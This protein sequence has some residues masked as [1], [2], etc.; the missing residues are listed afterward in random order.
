MNQDLALSLRK[1]EVT[2]FSEYLSLKAKIE[3]KKALMYEMISCDIE[4]WQL[5]NRV[6]L[7]ELPDSETPG[8]QL[9]CCRRP[10]T[11]SKRNRK[12]K[13]AKGVFLT[14]KVTSPRPS[15]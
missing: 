1:Q 8:V 13:L 5:L 4:T 6:D 3:R 9:E 2:N 11:I 10:L 14:L 12:I 15:V 7:N